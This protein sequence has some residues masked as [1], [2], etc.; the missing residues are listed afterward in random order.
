ML[1]KSATSLLTGLIEG[2]SS[3]LVGRDLGVVTKP[4][5]SSVIQQNAISSTLCVFRSVSIAAKGCKP[6]LQSASSAVG[7][8]Q[9]NEMQYQSLPADRTMKHNHQF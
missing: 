3:N 5:F 4:G 2:T 9:K 6:I 8:G 7:P 1:R